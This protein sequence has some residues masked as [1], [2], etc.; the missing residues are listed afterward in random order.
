VSERLRYRVLPASQPDAEPACSMTR[1]DGERRGG[2][3]SRLF[4][5]LTEERQTAE[6][7]EFVFRGEPDELWEQAS[8][9]VDEEAVCCPFF[10]YELS[11]TPDGVVLRVKGKAPAAR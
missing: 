8:V 3:M 11:E 6:G 5:K 7:N 4:S 2:D 1:E 9:F 10:T